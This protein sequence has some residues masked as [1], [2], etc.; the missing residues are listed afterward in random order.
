MSKKIKRLKA[1]LK[2]LRREEEYYMQY[3]QAYLALPDTRLKDELLQQI[4]RSRRQQIRSVYYE[5]DR[6]VIVLGQGGNEQPL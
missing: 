1:E 2:S 6:I 4:A 5:P 3:Y